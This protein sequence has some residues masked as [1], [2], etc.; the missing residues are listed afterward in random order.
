MPANRADRHA[1]GL[2]RRRRG[3]RRR[4][5]RRTC[6]ALARIVARHAVS[7][8]SPDGACANW[9]ST[10]CSTSPRFPSWALPASPRACRRIMRRI[11]Q[12]ADDIVACRPGYAG[13]DRQSR[14]HPPRGQARQRRLPDLPIVKYVCPSVWAWRPGRAK[15]M[16]DYD[17]PRAGA[18]ALRAEGAG[19][20]RRARCDLCRPSAGRRLA[21]FAGRDRSR[22]SPEPIAARCCPAPGAA[23]CGC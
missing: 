9:G 22:P 5:R 13:P 7:S 18:V 3:I 11:R 12:V 4:A 8:A 21:G 10:A 2:F 19:R 23:K 1:D 17:R 14:L 6:R 15:A 16:R 20:T